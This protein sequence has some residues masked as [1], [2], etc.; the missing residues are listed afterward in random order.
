MAKIKWEKPYKGPFS[1]TEALAIAEDMR[2]TADP[3]K[4]GILG[5]SIRK[6]AYRD[7]YDVFIKTNI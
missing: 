5:A 6:R 1:R 3:D 7:R 4:N 2:K